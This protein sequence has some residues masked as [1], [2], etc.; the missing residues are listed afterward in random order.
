MWKN[1]I[2]EKTSIWN[3]L[4][5]RLWRSSAADR[6]AKFHQ[7][8]LLAGEILDY[9]ILAPCEWTG[10]YDGTILRKIVCVTCWNISICKSMYEIQEWWFKISTALF[11]LYSIMSVGNEEYANKW[12]VRL[13]L[14][15][16]LVSICI[17]FQHWGDSCSNLES[18]NLKTKGQNSLTVRWIAK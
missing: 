7:I 13:A 10:V 15:N 16:Y 17:I 8:H 4:S 14:M 6:T 2:S 5:L 18:G 11:S 12:A 9:I 3:S 1:G